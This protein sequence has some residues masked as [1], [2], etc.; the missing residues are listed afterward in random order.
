MGYFSAQY[1]ANYF[2]G[3]M[4]FITL[5]SLALI[6]LNVHYNT[7]KKSAREQLQAMDANV[8]C[9]NLEDLDN[10]SGRNLA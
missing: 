7:K 8:Q 4:I 10:K 2:K 6:F 1:G 3:G 9:V 5:Q